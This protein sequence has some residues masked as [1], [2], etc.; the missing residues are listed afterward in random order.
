ME[1]NVL[2]RRHFLS[3]IPALTLSS[4]V[5]T[6]NFVQGN[7]FIEETVRNGAKT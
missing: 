5:K 7:R 4:I 6:D 3:F 1:N 2:R